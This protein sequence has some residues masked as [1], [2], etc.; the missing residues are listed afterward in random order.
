MGIR[1]LPYGDKEGALFINLKIPEKSC[2]FR[3]NDFSKSDI[4]F[5]A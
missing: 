4:R 1:H 3:C 5:Q 2:F